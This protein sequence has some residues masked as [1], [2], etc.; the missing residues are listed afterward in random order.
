M[1]ELTMLLFF[2]EVQMITFYQLLT[3]KT[4]EKFTQRR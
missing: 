1:T 2:L 3:S 4:I